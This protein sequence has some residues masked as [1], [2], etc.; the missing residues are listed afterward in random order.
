MEGKMKKTV[1]II[2]TLVMCVAIIIPFGASAGSPLVRS[3]IYGDVEG[4]AAESMFGKQLNESYAWLGVQYAKAP[5]GELRWMAPQ[6]PDKW[7]GV[8]DAK[9]I[10]QQCTQYGGLMSI[11]ECDMI[12][13]VVGGEDCLYLNI[14]RPKSDK[15]GLPVFFWI[16]GGANIVGQ[17]GMSLYNGSN[18][19]ARTDMIFVSLNYRLGPMGWMAHSALENGDPVN[20]S[21]NFG[22]LDIIRALEWVQANIKAFGGDPN[23]V[24]IAGESAGGVNVYTMLASP[25]AK[26]LFHKAISESGAPLFFSRKN[27]LEDSEILLT[28][29]VINDGLADSKLSAKKYLK[30][31]DD[32]FIASY[33]REKTIEE[34]FA[35]YNAGSMGTTS[36]TATV[37]VD[38]TVIVDGGIK[39]FRTGNYNKVPFLVGNNAQEAKLFLPTNLNLM[40]EVELCEI[41]KEMDTENPMPQVR[42][43]LPSPIINPGYNLIGKVSG[44]GF[45][46]VGVDG[47]ANMMKKYQDDI[48]VYR[49]IWDN[50]PEPMDFIIG[51]AHAVEM[52]F[53]FGNFQQGENDVLRFAWNSENYDE[54]IALS[55]QMM[56]YWSN[57]AKTGDPNAPGLPEWGTWANK[58][59]KPKRMILDGE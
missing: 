11:M 55:E 5:V 50:E 27:G 24:T 20:D 18:F 29:L 49:F 30:G 25:L 8:R 1:N 2:V 46:E 53:V 22:T 59:G 28:K 13:K 33:L 44:A 17:S 4:V 54:V 19:A 37:F 42:P 12:G 51:S 56:A 45:Q 36:D 16:H 34:I 32:N 39:T 21:G 52:P 10:C 15:E 38:G 58:E 23:N 14:W 3:T 41:I 43:H 47:P 9:V 26:G 57:F 7:S 6:K 48:Y 35:M 40:T 31:K